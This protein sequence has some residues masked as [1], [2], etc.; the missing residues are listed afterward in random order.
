MISKSEKQL[1]IKSKSVN[2]ILHQFKL[3]RNI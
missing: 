3:T 2:L 1:Y